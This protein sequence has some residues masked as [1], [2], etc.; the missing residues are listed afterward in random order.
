MKLFQGILIMTMLLSACMVDGEMWQTAV[1]VIGI[2]VAIL[3]VTV[4][5]HG[6]TQEG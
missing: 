1:K 4:I 6:Q 5:A 3:F 2:C